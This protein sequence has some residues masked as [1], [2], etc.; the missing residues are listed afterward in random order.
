MPSEAG[1]LLVQVLRKIPIF[2]GLSPTQTKRILGICTYKSY[3][4]GTELCLSD[5]PSDEM[6][7]L[8]S[9]GLSILT[10]EGVRVA[11][12]LPVTTVGEM[13]VITGQP[14]SAT[15][16][17][18]SQ[19]N[20][21]VVNKQAFDDILSEDSDM[22]ST[23]YRNIIDVLSAKLNNDNVRMSAYQEEKER[24]EMRLAASERK[25][26]AQCLRTEAAVNMASKIGN[27]TPEEISMHIDGE[28]QGFTPRV[29]IVDD[30]VNTLK[31]LQMV[32][33]A[34]EKTDRSFIYCG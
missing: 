28:A 26:A 17:V 5:S 20:I 21:F 22:R 18:S 34:G 23:V 27:M 32:E 1:K 14:R 3:S 9:G 10:N 33:E 7:I 25:L 15:V 2:K 12:I 13:G 19:S 24:F 31:S 11:T 8:L 6:Y 29:L 16:E 4:A 30:E